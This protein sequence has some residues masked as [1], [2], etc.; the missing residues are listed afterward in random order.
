MRGE[1]SETVYLLELPQQLGDE[2][3]EGLHGAVL[4]DLLHEL[5][6]ILSGWRG[7]HH[8]QGAGPF[9]EVLWLHAVA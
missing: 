6:V 1:G 2:K 3:L 9:Q 4:S 5:L 7:H 8:H